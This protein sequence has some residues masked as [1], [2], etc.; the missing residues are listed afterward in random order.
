MT[1][2]DCINGTIIIEHELSD[3]MLE[4]FEQSCRKK[5]VKDAVFMANVNG[6]KVIE[7]FV[8]A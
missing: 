5:D 7:A 2:I 3:V 6:C 4:L 1:E 8:T